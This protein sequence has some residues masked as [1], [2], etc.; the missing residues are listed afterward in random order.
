MLAFKL[1]NYYNWRNI[2]KSFGYWK[3][4]CT[5]WPI[6][7]VN[8]LRSWINCSINRKLISLTVTKQ[9][10]IGN[11]KNNDK[12]EKFQL[13]PMARLQSVKLAAIRCIKLRQRWWTHPLVYYPFLNHRVSRISLK[14]ELCTKIQCFKKVTVLPMNLIVDTWSSKY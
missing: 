11:N 10:L 13:P 12:Y 1:E 14:S 4:S 7:I 8:F 3:S 5:S 9:N 2:L 6:P